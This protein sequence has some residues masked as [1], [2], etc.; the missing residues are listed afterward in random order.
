MNNFFVITLYAGHLVCRDL[1]SFLISLPL[2]NKG[3]GGV[4]RCGGGVSV[5]GYDDGEQ[6]DDDNSSSHE[7]LMIL[8]AMDFMKLQLCYFGN[9]ALRSSLLFAVFG[10]LFVAV[11]P[12]LIENEG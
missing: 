3:A 1:S 11:I 7:A 4:D 12:L 10:S 5:S 8:T 2:R 6:D 9:M